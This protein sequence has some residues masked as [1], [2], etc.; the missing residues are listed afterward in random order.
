MGTSLT[1]WEYQLLIDEWSCCRW[2]GNV[3]EK[4]SHP[5]WGGRFPMVSKI[6]RCQTRLSRALR[7]GKLLNG[8]TEDDR[9]IKSG[10]KPGPSP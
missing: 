6:G 1:Y 7:A 9:V 8:Y 2:T 4:T 5:P 3:A 10:W